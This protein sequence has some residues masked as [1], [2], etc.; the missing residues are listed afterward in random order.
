MRGS[1]WAVVV[2]GTC[3]EAPRS[4]GVAAVPPRDLCRKA[5]PADRSTSKTVGYKWRARLQGRA[6]GRSA[7]HQTHMA[8]VFGFRIFWL[9]PVALPFPGS[10]VGRAR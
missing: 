4:R 10:P 1:C 6:V 7:Q 9:G 5:W 8:N 2:L 3:R